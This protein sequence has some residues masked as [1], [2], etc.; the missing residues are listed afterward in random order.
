[1]L[2]SANGK[3]TKNSIGGTT[4]HRIDQARLEISLQSCVS[5]QS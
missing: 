4:T 5:R 3:T 2:R 1:M